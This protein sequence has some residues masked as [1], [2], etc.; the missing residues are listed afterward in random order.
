MVPCQACRLSADGGW[1]VACGVV[2][3][4]AVCVADGAGWAEAVKV[5]KSP[6]RRLT[7][8]I[9][10]KTLMTRPRAELEDSMGVLLQTVRAVTG[11]GSPIDP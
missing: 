5:E 1:G 9:M 6:D 2:C 7:V 11:T 4:G 8:A 10:Q 3:E